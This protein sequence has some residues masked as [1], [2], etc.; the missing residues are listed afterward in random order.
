VKLPTRMWL[1]AA[2]IIIST[3]TS[4]GSA[5]LYEKPAQPV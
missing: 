1:R 2:S 4:S 5:A 3:I